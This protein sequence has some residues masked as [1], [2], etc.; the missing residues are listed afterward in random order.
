MREMLA[1]TLLSGWLA[2]SACRMA[3]LGIVCVSVAV[4]K[5]FLSPY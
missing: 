5:I 4:L 1:E 2:V 3:G